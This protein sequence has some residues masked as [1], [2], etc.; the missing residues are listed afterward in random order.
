MTKFLYVEMTWPEI[1]EVM[2]E[3]RVVLQPVATIEDHGRHLPI[4][5]DVLITDTICRRTAERIPN[6]IVL[7]PTQYHGYSPHHMDFPGTITVK[8]P[9]LLEYMLDITR[10]L[11]HHG[12][13]RILLVNG[14]GSNALWLEAVARLTIVEHPDTLC[15]M[16]SWWNIPEVV[17]AVNKM[18]TGGSGSTDHAAEAETSIMLALRPDLV[19]MSLAE[20][21]INYQISKYFPPVDLIY[22]AGAS[23]RVTPKMMPYWSTR[24]KTG[25]V[26]DPTSAT[27]EKGE[28]WIEAAITGLI[29]ILREFKTFEIR[30]RIDHH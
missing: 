9:T 29:G 20:K 15:G 23:K 11:I 25:T 16:L 8:G 12:F 2:K 3:N 22:P 19:D 1:N 28:A 4:V 6:E 10:S 14:H 13:R 7:M 18:R 30:D 24:S 21:D 27:Q 5:T 26:G 17:E